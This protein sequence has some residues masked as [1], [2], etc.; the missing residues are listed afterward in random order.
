MST[1]NDESYELHILKSV[2]NTYLDRVLPN[3]E[4]TLGSFTSKRDETVWKIA[5]DIYNQSGYKVKFSIIR[6]VVDSRIETLKIQ[7]LAEKNAAHER[8]KLQKAEKAKR[9]VEAD[10]LYQNRLIELANNLNESGRDKI[11]SNLFLRIQDIV[12]DKLNVERDTIA[13][14][15]HIISDLGADALDI[16]ELSMALEEEFDIEIPEDIL[17]SAS[18]PMWIWPQSSSNSFDNSEPTACT[19]GEILDFIH[20]QLFKGNTNK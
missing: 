5:T 12:S 14:N 3:T 6:D 1:E 8:L 19:I 7:L 13:L 17:C 9:I 10:K 2:I 15:H 18:T 4:E 16:T 11:M 20:K